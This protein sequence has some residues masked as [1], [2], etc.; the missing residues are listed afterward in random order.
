MMKS[1]K[2]T[3]EQM[4]AIVLD[5]IQAY[6]HEIATYGEVPYR[7][8]GESFAKNYARRLYA[9]LGAVEEN[10]TEGNNNA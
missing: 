7:G 4:K 6:D 8:Y 2:I 10:P 3:E 5:A 9:L 1:A